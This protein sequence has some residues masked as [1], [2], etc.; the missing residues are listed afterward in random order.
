VASKIVYVCS[1]LGPIGRLP[2]EKLAEI[3]FV[4]TIILSISANV[5]LSVFAL[6]RHVVDKVLLP[7]GTCFSVLSG[8]A[9]LLVGCDIT[10]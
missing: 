5:R 10:K 9:V 1:L 8:A 2:A 6:G 4:P 7:L 3:F